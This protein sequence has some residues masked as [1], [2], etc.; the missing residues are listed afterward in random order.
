MDIL[1]LARS[2][3]AADDD[4]AP[5]LLALK[6][7]VA[8]PPDVKARLH[9]YS[10]SEGL[11]W[12]DGHRLCLPATARPLAL[13][14][15]HDSIASGHPGI[16]STFALLA[17]LYHWPGMTTAVVKNVSSCDSAIWFSFVRRITHLPVISQKTAP[18]P[19]WSS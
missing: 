8:V 2:D 12:F 16:S 1:G 5:Y 15:A 19:R 3:S 6:D 9:L 18:P 14:A 7:P 13:H 11:L 17:R 4:L 10:E